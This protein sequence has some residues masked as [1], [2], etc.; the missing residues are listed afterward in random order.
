M[1]RMTGWMLVSVLALGVGCLPGGEDTFEE[2]PASGWQTAEDE[3][4]ED[5]APPEEEEPG[6]A[7]EPTDPPGLPEDRVRELLIEADLR[8]L[9]PQRAPMVTLTSR[10]PARFEGDEELVMALGEGY[11][12][13][14]GFGGLQRSGAYMS[15]LWTEGG[16]DLVMMCSTQLRA[17][18]EHVQSSDPAI[19]RADTRSDENFELIPIGAG[20][21]T[22]EVRVRLTTA[23]EPRRV[24]S[25][26]D[27]AT[28]EALLGGAGATLHVT[29]EVEI[30]E[31]GGLAWA[32][33]EQCQSAEGIRLTEGSLARVR[34]ELGRAPGEPM[35]AANWPEAEP[36]ILRYTQE[37]PP[38]QGR[39]NRGGELAIESTQGPGRGQLISPWGDTMGVE[40]LGLERVADAEVFFFDQGGYQEVEGSYTGH[41][42]LLVGHGPI[43][44]EDGTSPCN[45]TLDVELTSQT[46]E[47]CQI[48]EGGPARVTFEPLDQAVEFEREGTCEVTARW[49]GTDITHTYSLSWQGHRGR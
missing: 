14:L 21:A 6:P 22:V 37:Q 44:L 46:P 19:V 48:V 8:D 34:Y 9:R 35:E 17:R 13:V 7:P 38:V 43:T 40:V 39:R 36:L 2:E 29:Y 24:H 47:V 16:A 1:K 18:T 20:V 28:C 25:A 27:I 5:E 41:P 4:P 31:P 45:T 26:E 32:R 15:T 11:P 10:D 49:P 30:H 33:P 3:A 23:G 12:E 42:R